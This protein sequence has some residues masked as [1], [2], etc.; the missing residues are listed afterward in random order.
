MAKYYQK[1]QFNELIPGTAYY[2]KWIRKTDGSL[3]APT[4]DVPE[5]G[6]GVFFKKVIFLRFTEYYAYPAKNSM[7]FFFEDITG[8]EYNAKSIALAGHWVKQM[9]DNQDNAMKTEQE[10][11]NLRDTFRRLGKLQHEAAIQGNM[12]AFEAENDTASGM[13]AAVADEEVAKNKTSVNEMTASYLEAKATRTKPTT[14]IGKMTAAWA[15]VNRAESNVELSK[16]LIA[17]LQV[18][19]PEE[20]AYLQAI[21]ELNKRSD[22]VIYADMMGNASYKGG[23]RPRDKSI[24][25]VSIYSA[26]ALVPSAFGKAHPGALSGAN[27]NTVHLEHVKAHE[28]G[29]FESQAIEEAESGPINQQTKSLYRCLLALK[30]FG[31][32]DSTGV[33][34][35]SIEKFFKPTMNVRAQVQVN[36]LKRNV[37]GNRW[38]SRRETVVELPT[39]ADDEKHKGFTNKAVFIIND[40]KKPFPMSRLVLMKDLEPEYTIITTFLSPLALFILVHDFDSRQLDTLI[41]IIDFLLEKGSDPLQALHMACIRRDKRLVAHIIDFVERRVPLVQEFAAKEMD[42][43]DERLPVLWSTRFALA[44]GFNQHAQGFH[45][46]QLQANK[47]DMKGKIIPQPPLKSEFVSFPIL[48]LLE[49]VISDVQSRDSGEIPIIGKMLTRGIKVREGDADNSDNYIHRLHVTNKLLGTIARL[50][51]NPPPEPPYY[52]DGG[53][54]RIAMLNAGLE[55]LLVYLQGI[56]PSQNSLPGGNAMLGAE[57][58]FESL[59]G[60]AK[61]GSE[62]RAEAGAGSAE[63]RRRIGRKS[64]KVMN[65]RNRRTRRNL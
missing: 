8:S 4:G 43:R 42:E 54:E 59:A 23:K 9:K 51:Q 16:E 5:G 11:K 2:L 36:I 14:A 6:E 47:K 31:T 65:A 12:N 56:K 32:G 25:G 58:V 45:I 10:R 21:D 17:K 27:Y 1:L 39:I 48:A 50:R 44:N 52:Y 22:I 38:S 57:A 20:L 64:R 24:N 49:P 19:S 30:F 28:L 29:L 40:S 37:G 62:I 15:N 3:C 33:A 34:D 13:A 63:P 55:E 61:K 26:I 18:R 46:T 41:K 60:T 35:V 53:A 7:K